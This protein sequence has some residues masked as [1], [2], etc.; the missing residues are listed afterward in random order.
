M[1]N[2][3]LSIGIA[4]IGVVSIV[5]SGAVVFSMNQELTKTKDSLKVAENQISTMT[6]ERA[7]LQKDL[8]SKIQEISTLQSEIQDKV[9]DVRNLRVRTLQEKARTQIV[10]RCLSGVIDVIKSSDRDQAFITLGKIEADCKQA[11]KIIKS[12]PD[13][14]NVQKTDNSES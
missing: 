4:T 13:S 11:G 9:G 8:E 12:D 5:A 10:S 2:S 1:N 7:N 3:S 6:K 14:P